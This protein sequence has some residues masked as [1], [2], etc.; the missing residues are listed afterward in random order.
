MNASSP[1]FEFSFASSG[2]TGTGTFCAFPWASAGLYTAGVASV[3]G[4][5]AG[6]SGDAALEVGAAVV[7]PVWEAALPDAVPPP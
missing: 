1:A 4:L 3:A 6:V 2:I 7:E 5:P